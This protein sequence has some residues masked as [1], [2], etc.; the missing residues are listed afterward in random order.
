[1][2]ESVFFGSFCEISN[3]KPPLFYCFD[4]FL[5]LFDEMFSKFENLKK[6]SKNYFYI[7]KSNLVKIK[8]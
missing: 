6:D 1:M 3:S 8:G 7:I 4:Y 2:N 5:L